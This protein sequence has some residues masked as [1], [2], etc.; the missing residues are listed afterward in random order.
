MKSRN[1]SCCPGKASVYILFMRRLGNWLISWEEECVSY[2]KQ[3]FLTRVI[4]P[5][6][7]LEFFLFL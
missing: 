4:S 2:L 1:K 3:L 6:L 7:S 5:F